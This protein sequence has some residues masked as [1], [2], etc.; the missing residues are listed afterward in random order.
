MKKLLIVSSTIAMAMVPSLAFAHPGPAHIHGLTDGLLHPLSGVDHILAMVA[1][2]VLAAQ[3][4]GRALW[5]TPLSFMTMMTVGA[6]LGI[7]HIV[8]PFVEVGIALSIITLGVVLMFG[9][10]LPTVTAAALVG[11]FAVFHGYAHGAEIPSAALA[12]SYGAGFVL[13]TGLLH[14]VGI[15]LGVFARQ[16]AITLRPRL[17]RVAGATFT[18]AG[19]A[20]LVGPLTTG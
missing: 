2:G 16:T 20:A 4:G 8:V 14:L 5:I 10:G 12:L 11:F 3:L 13:A 15:S 9:V 7:A 1:V 19:I 6:V 18:I 17:F